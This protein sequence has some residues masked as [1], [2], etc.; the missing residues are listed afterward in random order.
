MLAHVDKERVVLH[1]S[2]RLSSYVQVDDINTPIQLNFADGTVAK[3]DVLIGCDGIHSPVRHTMLKS[4]ADELESVGGSDNLARAASLR[5]TVEAQWS[6]TVSYR[7]VI[8]SSKLRAL[9]PDHR[10]LTRPFF[11][12][13]LARILCMPN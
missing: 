2:K 1:N 5:S 13:I 6:G 3:A 7:E 10:L 12:R 11:V 9:N 8:P 4:E